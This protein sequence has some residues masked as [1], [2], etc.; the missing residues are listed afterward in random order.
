MSTKAE[1]RAALGDWDDYIKS[2]NR[3][4]VAE[5]NESAEDKLK[6][7]NDL[8]RSGNDEAWF[9]YYFP[10]YYYAEPA[11]FHKKS[12]SLVMNNPELYL[13]RAWSRELAKT[14]RTMM[15]T[16]KQAMTGEKRAVMLISNSL[17]VAVRLLK[18]YKVTFEKNARLINDYGVQESFGEW[19]E[20]CFVV[21]KGCLFIAVGAGQTPRGLKNEEV[22]PDKVIID[23]FDT[24]ADCLN[25]EINDKKW[26]WFEQ[27]VYATRSI[28]NP[29]QVVFCGNIIS[30]NSCINKAIEMA[31]Y[32]EIINIRDKDGKSTWPQKNTEELIDRALSKIS[33][34]SQQK[35]YYNNPVRKG[36]VFK[37]VTYGKT[38]LPKSCKFLIAYADPA[39]SNKDRTESKSA[40]FKCVSIVGLKDF[41]YYV[42]KVWLDQVGNGTFVDWLFEA[43]RWMILNHIDPKRIY[44]ENNTLQDPFYQQVILPLIKQK[45][46]EQHREDLP[47][48]TPD[49]RKKPDKYLRIEGTLEPIARV[50]NLVFDEQLKGNPHMKIMETQMLSV[51]PTAKKIDG[52]DDIEGAVHI[53]KNKV[54]ADTANMSSRP[55]QTRNNR[56]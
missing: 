49:E 46:K 6:R 19:T 51:S 9:K 43:E 24:D 26:A 40:S 16:I 34:E 45:A 21:K 37:D 42:Y 52:P 39:T 33:W 53:L 12:T 13:V 36:K 2:L 55:P 15:E 5:I 44:V 23:D 8:E 41:K 18:G 14:A 1:D 48:V 29:M 30:E 22:R 25:P 17:D 28:S 32:A 54:A 27:A 4:T 11:P 10:H 47:P 7:M 31:D 3:A 50:G 35:E 20:E 38:P 56:R